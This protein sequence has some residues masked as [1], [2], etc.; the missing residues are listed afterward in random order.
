MEVVTVA[1]SS[2]PATRTLPTSTRWPA[3][4]T[5]IRVFLAIT[6]GTYGLVKVLGGQYNYGDW[7]IDKK[8]VDGTSLV[9]AFY[10]YS[11]MYGHFTGLFELVPAILLLIPRTATIGAAALFAVALNITAMDFGFHYPAVKYFALGYT[12]LL[13]VVLWAD[14]EKLSL[15]LLDRAQARAVAATASTLPTEARGP[16]FSPVA[17]RVLLTLGGLFVL[18]E[19]NIGALSISKGPEPAARRAV[20]AQMRPNE[21]LELLRSRQTGLIGLDWTATVDYAV[22][23]TGSTDTVTV[24]ARKITALIPWRVTGVTSTRSR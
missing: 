9:W 15:L 10:G 2:V 13:A 3:T 12:V 18:V 11:P 14:R 7:V 20:A 17:R 8:T 1:S 24:H 23:G 6:F 16:V 22:I 5:V 19:A 4:L 21:R